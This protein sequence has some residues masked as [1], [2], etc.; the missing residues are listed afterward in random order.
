VNGNSWIVARRASVRSFCRGHPDRGSSN[1]SVLLVWNAR[2]ICRPCGDRGSHPCTLTQVRYGYLSDSCLWEWRNGP[3]RAAPSNGLTEMQVTVFWDAFIFSTEQVCG[4]QYICQEWGGHSSSN[5]LT[6]SEV[7]SRSGELEDSAQ[8]F[9]HAYILTLWKNGCIR[10]C[11][12][13]FEPSRR[14]AWRSQK[15][16][17]NFR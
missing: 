1:S 14:A 11:S 6:R 2:A 17:K 3:L 15:S 5:E 4:K 10:F 8:T 7:R 9:W 12:P 16:K 13:W